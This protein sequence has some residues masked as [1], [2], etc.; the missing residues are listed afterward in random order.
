MGVRIDLLRCNGCGSCLPVCPV[1]VLSVVDMK[2]E[3]A[4]GCIDC[5]AC[6]DVCTFHAIALEGEPAARKE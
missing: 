1:G 6:V 2:C 4:E 3:A 5:G